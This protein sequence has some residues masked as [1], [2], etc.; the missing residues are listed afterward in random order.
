[1]QIRFRVISGIAALLVGFAA[2]PARAADAPDTSRWLIHDGPNASPS[3]AYQWL[4]IMQEA[5]AREVQRDGARPT[6]ISRDMVIVTTAMYDAWAAYDDRAVGTRLGGTLRRPHNEH[7]EANKAKAIA[8]ACFRALLFV[9][10][11]DAEWMRG[12]MKRMGYDPDDA[13]AN[14]ATPQ[15][16]GNVA[17]GAVIEFRRS[18][19]ANQFGD[20]IGSSGQ[21]YS[22]YTYYEPVN[23][24]GTFGAPGKVVDP[25]R[26]QQIPFSDGKGGTITPGFLT[27]HW[28]RVKPLVLERSNMFRPPP[29][30]KVGSSQL[31]SEVDEVI[32]FN[33]SLSMEQRAL[34]EFMR[35]GPKSTGQSGHWLRFALDVS[36]RDHYGVD[37]DVKLF[38]SVAGVAFDAFIACWEAKRFYDSSRP[39]TLVR[40]Y[41]KGKKIRGWAGPGHGVLTRLP[42][43]QWHPYSP[44]T[45]V[46]PPFPGYPS[47]HSTVSGASAR[48]LELF[49]GSD[50]LEVV[51]KHE[52]GSLTGEAH[53]APAKILGVDGKLWKDAPATANVDL[54][55]PTFTATAQ[56]A[57]LSRI[58]GGYHIQTDNLEGIALG[59]KV[60]EYSWPKYEAYFDGTA[61]RAAET[62]VNAAA[63]GV[64]H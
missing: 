23:P 3:A 57:G 33:A 47:G 26:W 38:F 63:V 21:S 48:L 12:E 51:C 1:M 36:R 61:Q 20:E 10:P 5:S 42:A 9:H 31:K 17:A 6:I 2:V 30:P 56:M 18:D 45:F 29:P 54:A 41:Y 43:E 15:G 60:A 27:P 49:T 53:F 14:P 35:D 25:D 37:Q 22:D 8:F 46:T 34:V 4:E 64:A 13:T 11:E 62:R 39:W 59:R 24:P 50:R 58:M 19:G 32:D 44:D 40:W 16:I 7:T 55:C 28:Y 52:A